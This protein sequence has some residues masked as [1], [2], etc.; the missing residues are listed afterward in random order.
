MTR[1]KAAKIILDFLGPKDQ[2][3]N[4]DAI[5]ILGGSSLSPVKKAAVLFKKGFSDKIFFTSYGGTFTNLE[6][7]DGEAK[8]YY[9]TLRALGIPD[10]NIFWKEATDNTLDEAKYAISFMKKRGVAPKTVIL[11]SRPVHQRRAFATFKKQNPSVSFINV[12]ADEKFSIDKK[13]IERLIGE[14]KRLK[15]Y[16]KKGDL[17]TQKFPKEVVAAFLFLKKKSTGQTATK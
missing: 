4:A 14:I 2:L 3:K 1:E 10:K 13:L 17:V 9:K 15:K 6:W 7:K 8:M 16:A 12:P 11:I 5:F